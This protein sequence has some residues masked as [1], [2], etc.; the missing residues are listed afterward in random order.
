MHSVE[1][2]VESDVQLPTALRKRMERIRKMQEDEKEERTEEVQDIQ[3]PAPE[4]ISD[5]E[6]VTEPVVVTSPV[7]PEFNFASADLLD[8][9]AQKVNDP[10]YWRHRASAMQGMFRAEQ[11][12]LKDIIAA[13]DSRIGELEAE[14]VKLQAE[15]PA[16]EPA[17]DLSKFFTPDQLDDI[18]EDHAKFLIK[19]AMA[20]AR[21]TVQDQIAKHIEPQRK[22]QQDTEQERKNAEWN[23]FLER[24]TALV[25]NWQ[26]INESDAWKLWLS[27]VD[28]VSGFER[29]ELLDRATDRRDDKRTAALFNAFLQS[30]GGERVDVSDAPPVVPKGNA[31]GAGGGQQSSALMPLKPGEAK[32]YYTRKARNKTTEEEDALFKKR[33]LLT[34][35]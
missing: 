26:V 20:A 35:G 2:N 33:L 7:V 6:K 5:G 11:K 28:D 22:A 12:R 23:S 21:E 19:T 1:S 8:A 14:V 25:P 15:K 27:R 16:V 24:L 10:V 31:A 18:G 4:V 3:N 30:Q 34:Y 17:I 13:R 29:Q 32:D 9:P